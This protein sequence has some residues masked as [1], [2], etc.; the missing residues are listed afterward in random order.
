MYLYLPR[1]LCALKRIVA[2]D[3]HER[4]GAS[5]GILIEAIGDAA[6]TAVATDGKRLLS[7]QG[8]CP[9]KVP[10]WNGLTAETDDAIS[11]VLSLV[12]LDKAF[13]VGDAYLKTFGSVGLA[14]KGDSIY[15]G[16]GDD[17]LCVRAVSGRFP[18]WRLVMPKGSPL[19]AVRVDPKLFAETM[20]ALHDMGM[21]GVDLLHYGGDNVMGLRAMSEDYLIEGA[22]VPLVRRPEKDVPDKKE[23]N[24][25]DATKDPDP[26][27]YDPD[28]CEQP[29]DDPE[30]LEK[31]R[32]AILIAK[33]DLSADNLMDCYD[34]ITDCI[35]ALTEWGVTIPE[36]TPTEEGAFEEGQ[37]FTEAPDTLPMPKKKGR[38]KT[39]DSPS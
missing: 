35:D 36:R 27:E 5:T 26:E 3:Q 15:L 22:I 31:L 24:E 9:D 6:F 18:N 25:P 2:R 13:K 33:P 7:V 39:C 8:N 14:T 29:E 20:L 1:S 11:T 23:P 16:I 28:E 32:Q 4:F 30:Y 21:T 19:F 17:C 38:K 10:H 37:G 12:D 34:N